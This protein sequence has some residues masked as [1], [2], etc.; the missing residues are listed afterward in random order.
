MT[1]GGCRRSVAGTW[2]ASAAVTIFL[3]ISGC[4]A[5]HAAEQDAHD[6]CAK[7]GKHAVIVARQKHE[8][9]LV[10]TQD[11]RGAYAQF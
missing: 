7:Q 8:N 1:E 5:M 11:E 9:D 3:A 10:R 4:D 6:E 2:A